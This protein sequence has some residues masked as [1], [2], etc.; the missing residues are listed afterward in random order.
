MDYFR[1]QKIGVS[2]GTEYT[3]NPALWRSH[4]VQTT[5][6]TTGTCV[7]DTKCTTC[8]SGQR[9]DEALTSVAVIPSSLAFD[10]SVLH[11]CPLDRKLTFR[12]FFRLGKLAPLANVLSLPLPSRP[13]RSFRAHP[14]PHPHPD[15]GHSIHI[16]YPRSA[17]SCPVDT[18]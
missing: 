2:K 5:P 8:R 13:F 1:Q 16:F 3:F 7:P 9:E 6:Q 11:C 18:L 15:H 12:E 17:T 14:H 10:F 4:S